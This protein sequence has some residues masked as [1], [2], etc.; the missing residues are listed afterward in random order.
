VGWLNLPNLLSLARLALAP[1]V[2]AAVLA[3]RN[4]TALAILAVAA[5]TDVLDGPIARR[6]HC[7]TRWG[8]YADPI[9]DKVLLSSSYVALGM[10]GLVPWWLVGL[11]FGRD[12][13]ILALAGG[14]L[15][16]TGRRD[17]PP[18]VWG[19]LSTL[20]QGL[21]AVLV[22]AG[23]RQEAL[24]WAAAAVT[25]WSGVHY[26]WRACNAPPAGAR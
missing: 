24:L 2:F 15:L 23:A 5:A 16:F 4:W 19:K 7:V 25:V 20:V 22:L 26:L 3:G 13:L 21:V 12:L 10:A 6:M 1:F 11:I 17:F 9:A 8:A 14:A 18:S